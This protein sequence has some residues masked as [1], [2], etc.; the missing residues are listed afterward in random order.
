VLR[1]NREMDR[2]L[3]DPEVV[4]KLGDI[5]VQASGA[6]TP[7]GFGRFIG[8]EYERWRKVIA[9]IGIEPE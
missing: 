9:E 8:D 5:G 2:A 7:E 1:M 4:Q 3:Q 6:D